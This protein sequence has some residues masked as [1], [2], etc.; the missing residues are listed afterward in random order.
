MLISLKLKLNSLKAHYG[1][2]MLLFLFPNGYIY[3]WC[4]LMVSEKLLLDKLP[5]LSFILLLFGNECSNS[6]KNFV[7]ESKYYFVYF[8]DKLFHIQ[9]YF[10]FVKSNLHALKSLFNCYWIHLCLFLRSKNI[11]V[12][13][14]YC[15]FKFIHWT[16]PY[17]KFS[18][19]SVELLLCK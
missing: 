11:F 3:F 1:P 12:A 15:A 6:D 10:L 5:E 18:W 8:N 19:W 7:W 16:G 2:E 14:A 17:R 13:E 9:S 4:T